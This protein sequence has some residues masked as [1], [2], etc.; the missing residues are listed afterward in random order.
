[1]AKK[2]NITFLENPSNGIYFSYKV[3]INNVL[4]P[5]NS[6]I[7]HLVLDFSN[8]VSDITNIQIQTTLNETINETLRILNTYYSY[9]A[10]VYTRV[11]DGIEVY[12]NDQ[13]ANVFDVLFVGSLSITQENVIPSETYFLKYFADYVDVMNVPYRIEILGKGYLGTSSLIGAYGNLTKGS[14]KN[15]LETIRGTG[16]DIELEADTSLTFEDLYTD[17]ENQYKVR[18]YRNNALLFLGFLKPDGIY[19]SFVQDRWVMTV[20]CVDGL[21]ILKDLAFVQENGFHWTGKQR[22]IDII[23]NCLYRT[24]TFMDIN[25]AVN[26]YYA[27]L[28]PSDNLD[29]LTQIYM[30]V[31]RFIKDDN[32][33]IMDCEEV[34]K[35]VLDLFN[36]Q[37]TQQDG[38]WYI[39]R[40]NEVVDNSIVKYRRY[41]KTDNS[42]KGINT[43]KQAFILGSQINNRYP[44]HCSGNQQITI[45]GTVAA[46]RLNYKYG[47]VIPQ[48]P[49][50]NFQHTGLSYPNWTVND[51]FYIITDP[52]KTTG[53]KLKVN[54]Y[55]SGKV[56]TSSA[57]EFV[58]NSQLNFSV[59]FNKTQGSL[60]IFEIKLTAPG[61][62]DKY[63]KFD[64]SLNDAPKWVPFNST[65]ASR[66]VLLRGMPAG[67]DGKYV[68][69]NVTI[70]YDGNVT[71]AIY[72]PTV[73]L[74]S[75][76]VEYL[77]LDIYTSKP[78]EIGEFHTVQRKDKVS[79][80]A[81]DTATIYNGDSPSIIYEGAIFKNDQVTPTTV[82]SRRGKGEVKP[83]LQ[84][85][86]E[87]VLRMSPKPSK[88][89][90][91]DVFGYI[92]YLS[93]INIDNIEGD[94]KFIE[95]NFDSKRNVTSCKM[96]QVFNFELPDI[97]YKMSYD[98][99]NSVKPTITS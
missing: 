80:I 75:G 32:N 12:V 68:L 23:Y 44:H 50:Y 95:Y 5:Y 6:G 93:L 10:I 70:P 35:S 13:T 58:A 56:M 59:K 18:F 31:N 51:P 39:E 69:E 14:V 67:D 85:A 98:Y 96:I 45:R 33:T 64:S 16:L 7:N 61:E 17:E 81:K 99:G 40:A 20:S 52:L 19:Q 89:F 94:F 47:F 86:A 72:S 46:F 9:S 87:D 36:A 3:S 28:I 63:L 53:L 42:F 41:S 54:S 57:V 24:N 37:I 34:L 74:L 71:I 97:D 79:S 55:I 62:A 91:G 25:T 15:A 65:L 8:S 76:T 88:E 1:M 43:K 48:L 30:S 22:A 92:P 4:I 27:G 77:E 78:L 60:L 2:I 11:D 49:N 82:W 83:I 38:Q 21:G 90:M 26:V 84:I 73:T 29:P 66:T